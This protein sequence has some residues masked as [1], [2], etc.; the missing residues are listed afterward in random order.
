VESV[1]PEEDQLLQDERGLG[2]VLGVQWTPVLVRLDG[3][4][5]NVGMYVDAWGSPMC[6]SDV[7]LQNDSRGR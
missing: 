2:K 6:V 3:N 5:C 4:P 7:V 1:F